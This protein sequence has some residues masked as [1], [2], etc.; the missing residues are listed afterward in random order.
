[1]FTRN[2]FGLGPIKASEGFRVSYGHKSVYYRDER[3]RFEL[4]YEDQFLFPGVRPMMPGC[5]LSTSEQALILE[6][7]CEALVWDG[8]RVEIWKPR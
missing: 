7:V 5:V 3:G 4:G 8:H 1:M 6:R 2:W